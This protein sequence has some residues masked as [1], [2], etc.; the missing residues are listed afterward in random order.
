MFDDSPPNGT[1]PIYRFLYPGVGE[2]WLR[3]RSNEYI[4]EQVEFWAGHFSESFVRQNFNRQQLTPLCQRMILGRM[5]V[6]LESTRRYWTCFGSTDSDV[7]K[8]ITLVRT[9]D[10]EHEVF[11][12]ANCRS[13]TFTDH[14]A[15]FCEGLMAVADSDP[16]IIGAAIRES[17]ICQSDR[18]FGFPVVLTENGSTTGSFI[19]L[20]RDGV[21]SSA[22]ECVIRNARHTDASGDGDIDIWMPPNWSSERCDDEGVQVDLDSAGLGAAVQA[23]TSASNW[24]LPFGVGFTGAWHQSL[25]RSVSNLEQKLKASR[26]AGLFVLFAC[27]TSDLRFP[28]NQYGVSVFF[29]DEGLRLGEVAD[30]V[31]QVAYRMGLT[32][33]TYRQIQPHLVDGRYDFRQAHCDSERCPVGFIGREAALDNL[34]AVDRDKSDIHSVCAPSRSGKTTLLSKF[35]SQLDQY[36]IW[37]AFD[38]NIPSRRYASD[39][40][41]SIRRQLSARFDVLDIRLDRNELS[42]DEY[43]LSLL[44]KR[45]QPLILIDGLDE[46][47]EIPQVVDFIAEVSR[48]AAVVFGSQPLRELK[49]LRSHP[50]AIPEFES[51]GIHTLARIADAQSLI[52]SYAA[53]FDDVISSQL[54]KEEWCDGLAMQA[55]GNLW[56]LTEFFEAILNERMGWPESPDEA[57]LSGDVVAYCCQLL[58]TVIIGLPV[59]EQ[60]FAITF[61]GVL[62]HLGGRQKT[63]V[64]LQLSAVLARYNKS[65]VKSVLDKLARLLKVSG[66]TSQFHSAFIEESLRESEFKL[67][68]ADVTEALAQSITNDGSNDHRDLADAC[69]LRLLAQND[70]CDLADRL[71]ENSPWLCNHV[72]EALEDDAK[73]REI[74]YRLTQLNYKMVD[75]VSTLSLWK[76]EIRSYE[77]LFPEWW[78]V[79]CGQVVP[80]ETDMQLLV[81]LPYGMRIPDDSPRHEWKILSD[82]Y[83]DQP[84]SIWIA[85]ITNHE[86]LRAYRLDKSL[87]Q[88][89]S[90]RTA[91]FHLTFDCSEH[92]STLTWLR[93][94]FL[95]LRGHRTASVIDVVT[96]E[97]VQN[98]FSI[99]W[100]IENAEQKILFKGSRNELSVFD[101]YDSVLIVDNYGTAHFAPQLPL[102]NGISLSFES[103]T[104]IGSRF[105]LLQYDQNSQLFFRTTEDAENPTHKKYG[106]AVCVV[107]VTSENGLKHFLPI[108]DFLL[109]VFTTEQEG[110]RLYSMY[111]DNNRQAIVLRRHSLD[112]GE[113]KE[114]VFTECHINDFDFGWLNLAPLA[115]ALVYT[116]VEEDS[117]KRRVGV[118]ALFDPE[119]LEIEKLENWDEPIEDHTS[120]ATSNKSSSLKE[121]KEEVPDIRI[122]LPGFGR[123]QILDGRLKIIA[124]GYEDCPDDIWQKVIAH[125]DAMLLERT[126]TTYFIHGEEKKNTVV[127]LLTFP[128]DE[129]RILGGYDIDFHTIR[130]PVAVPYSQTSGQLEIPHRYDSQV[131]QCPEEFGVVKQIIPAGERTFI[132]IDESDAVF[133]LRNGSAEVDFICENGKVCGHC[134]GGVLV[135]SGNLLFF[136]IADCTIELSNPFDKSIELKGLLS[137]H[138]AIVMIRGDVEDPRNIFEMFARQDTWKLLDIRKGTVAEYCYEKPAYTKDC[139]AIVHSLPSPESFLH[140]ESRKVRRDYLEWSEKSSDLAVVHTDDVSVDHFHFAGLGPIV[141]EGFG[142]TIEFRDLRAPIQPIAVGFTDDCIQDLIALENENGRFVVAVGHESRVSWFCIDSLWDSTK[143]S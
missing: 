23:I 41:Q 30:I 110:D 2:N 28:R 76:K 113:I 124:D 65:R 130:S 51:S 97:I 25:T 6:E 85:F 33:H 93:F 126:E 5:A 88:E 22:F 75:G 42:D 137:K 82:D 105:I 104:E 133:C 4:A 84:D 74:V 79:C 34:A 40:T 47:T 57:R 80:P 63:H 127:S 117:S 44:K 77:Q 48:Y 96:R 114:R 140:D 64:V 116:H 83:C 26:Q 17:A 128:D 69:L 108:G 13:V 118:G 60:E 134:H 18:R 10:S 8:V 135:I 46:S 112:T 142:N 53:R 129:G 35:A 136:Q 32:E 81:P 120:S 100:E 103:A 72:R 125:D 50:I 11:A 131:W 54:A 89:P 67:V 39:L 123:L 71:F 102:L 66:T 15:D 132:A 45:C 109:N 91:E 49:R 59:E 1:Q 58:D 121:S 43:I 61:F 56:I 92:G 122:D 52:Q 36:P 138:L 37:F 86:I 101:S 98:Q 38:R 143:R 29:I 115:V 19:P 141:A 21:P 12:T 111:F 99:D 20:I 62:S 7:D 87:L 73:M 95:F 24:E 70:C 106:N 94:P 119:T 14:Y 68:G 3:F 9:F 139:W 55:D 90:Q 78:A 27:G 16:G 107:S 31:N